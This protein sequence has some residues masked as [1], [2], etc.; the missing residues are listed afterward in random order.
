[1]GQLI[2]GTIILFLCRPNE[3][4]L[5]ILTALAESGLFSGVNLPF[6]RLVDPCVAWREGSR[7]GRSHV[8]N[9]RHIPDELYHRYSLQRVALVP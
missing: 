6:V 5:A 3:L 7:I 8:G 2:R 4:R 9:S 1:M